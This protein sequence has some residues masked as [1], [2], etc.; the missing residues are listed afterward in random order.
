MKKILLI[1]VLLNTL[2]I[3]GELKTVET[4][5]KALDI[6]KDANK[7]ILFMTSIESCPVCNYMKDVVFEKEKVINYLNQNYIMVIRDAEKETY[8]KRFY[9]RDMPTFYFIN[10]KSEKEIRAPKAGG[11]TPEKFLSVIQKA[12]EG[13]N[14]NTVAMAPKINTEKGIH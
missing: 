14:N 2:I 5:K 12:I 7:T 3:G 6:A 13:E 11:S 4:Y 8:P 1:L 9:T 10:P